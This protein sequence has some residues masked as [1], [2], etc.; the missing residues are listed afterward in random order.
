MPTVKSRL[1]RFLRWSEKYTKTDMVY[2]ARAGFWSNLNFVIVSVFALLLSIAFANLLPR[3]TYGTYQYLIALSGIITALTLAGMNSAVIQSVARGNE[4]DLRATVRVQLLWSAV[5][6]ALGLVGAFYYWFAGN[7]MTAIGLAIVALLAPIGNVYNTYQAFL[8]GKR[9]FKQLF[10]YTTLAA[11]AYYASMFVA[12]LFVKSA[13]FLVFVNLAV[14]TAVTFYAYRRTLAKYKPNDTTDQGTIPYG[15][16]LSVMNAFGTAIAQLDSVLV[17][18]FLG[19]A[20]LALY[21]FASLLP[22]R[23]GGLFKFISSAALPKFSTQTHENIRGT[24]LGKTLRAALAGVM[25]TLLYMFFAP[26]LFRVL[27]PAYLDAVHYTILYAAVIITL[28][29]NLPATALVAQQRK[30]EL[31]VYNLVN[32]VIL[33]ALQVPLLLSFGIAGI[34]VARIISNLFNI[35]LALVLIWYP[36]GKRHTK[37]GA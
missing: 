11:A 17:F 28:A 4:G 24:I 16:H 22:E 36:I 19:A 25:A 10:V 23:V 1:H 5:P 18:H 7:G 31:Y 30:R 37:Q 2:L 34:L 9:D 35:L 8:T 32:P 29:A 14:N 26:L 3:D 13:A 12:M 6:T 20:D 27:F 33:L 21:S 15:K